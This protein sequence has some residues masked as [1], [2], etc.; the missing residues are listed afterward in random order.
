MPFITI[1]VFCERDIR[2]GALKI[3]SLN[4]KSV[5]QIDQFPIAVKHVL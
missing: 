5:M 2:Q 1:I 4:P 3:A